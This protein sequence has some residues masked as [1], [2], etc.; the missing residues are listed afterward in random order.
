MLNYG[1]EEQQYFWLYECGHPE[2]HV[3]RVLWARHGR[4]G[5]Q[6]HA[7]CLRESD[8]TVARTGL[9][10]ACQ[11]LLDAAG[12]HYICQARLLTGTCSATA[13]ADFYLYELR[14]MIQVDGI[15]HTHKSCYD[16]ALAEQQCRDTYFEANTLLK[17]YRL[18]RLHHADRPFWGRKI[19]EA[20]QR[21][22]S[23][24]RPSIMYSV[25]F[26]QPDVQM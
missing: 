13:G 18:L 9:E 10:Q 7:C 14:L 20:V 22:R 1:A 23:T 17:Q 3:P 11:R 15:Q 4:G 6:C 24:P 5:K 19:A 25:K 26:D 21:A 2:F 8:P 12:L 16:T